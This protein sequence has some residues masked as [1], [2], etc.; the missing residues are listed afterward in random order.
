MSSG[1]VTEVQELLE[2]QQSATELQNEK[3][4]FFFPQSGQVQRASEKF[5]LGRTN[6]LQTIY[7]YALIADV[8]LSTDIQ[9]FVKCSY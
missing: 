2:E 4:F 5:R 9:L 6:F 8:L 1:P 7:R 3:L